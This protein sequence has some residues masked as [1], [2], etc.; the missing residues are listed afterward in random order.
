MTSSRTIVAV[1]QPSVM[2]REGALAALERMAPAPTDRPAQ[3]SYRRGIRSRGPVVALMLPAALGV[4]ALMLLNDSDSTARGVGGFAAAVLAAPLLP[5]FGAPIRSG[6][7]LYVMAVVSSA[8]V[9]FVVGTV[10]SRRATRGSTA[11]WGSFWAEY[12]LLAMS[13]WVGALLSLVAAN[14][15]LGRTLL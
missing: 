1:E 3:R 15:V 8:V 13:V 2:R 9:W 5:A 4:L 14:L 6:G 12:L 10:A 7:S 11:R